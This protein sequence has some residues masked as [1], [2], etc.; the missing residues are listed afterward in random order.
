[1]CGI[2]GEIRYDDQSADVGAVARMAESMVRRGPDADGLVSRGRVAFGH[3][4][5]K[6][7]DLSEHSQ[8]PLVDS[9][10]GLMITFNGAIYNYPELREE[11]DGKGYKFFSS[12]DTEVI[13]KA[14]HAWG[15]ECVERFNGMFAFAIH[16][17]DTGRVVLARD[18]LGIKPL[19]YTQS[20]GQLRFASTLPALVAAGD[21][22]TSIDP[23]ALN[24]YMSFHSVVPPPRTILSGVK[25][26][27]PAT[28]AVVEADGSLQ[29]SQYWDLQF[30][31]RPDQAGYSFD[32]WCDATL[33]VMRR[34]VKRRMVADVSVGVLL[35]GGLDSSLVVGLLCENGGDLETFSIGFDAVAGEEGDE[36]KYSDVIVERYRT[37]HHKLFI[38]AARTL[39]ALSECIGQMSEP[40]VSHDNVGFYL[41][42]QEVAKSLKVVQ[43]GQ[44]A[45][46]I[47]AGY[48]WYPPMLD[49]T[50]ALA[51]YQQAFF[52][53]DFAEYQQVVA[54]QYIREDAATACVRE[55]FGKPGARLPI[56]QALRIRRSC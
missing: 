41:L 53:R 37:K 39:P 12:G 1:M 35:S 29:T 46:E 54:D 4:R 32:D 15:L 56:D 9:Q 17:R 38:D 52:D 33:D 14:Y 27:P 45:D 40:M 22:D 21:V 25:K 3:R 2:C 30:G 31:Q 48:H 49:S 36:F 5:L 11:L 24:Y 34:A 16:E 20:P 18:R 50:D 19:Y 47:F 7:I 10:L 42:S 51:T 23:V 43:S 28:I 26:L 6:I 13:L 44:G 8:Q 55:H